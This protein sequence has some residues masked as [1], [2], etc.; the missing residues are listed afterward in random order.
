MQVSIDD[1]LEDLVES[2]DS[3]RDE[4]GDIAV[5]P[6]FQFAFMAGVKAVCKKFK[7]EIKSEKEPIDSNL[8]T[9]ER[10]RIEKYQHALELIRNAAKSWTNTNVVDYID[11]ILSEETTG[12]N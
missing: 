9:I 5:N 4:E 2:Y 7:I 8:Q 3:I 12:A 6:M 10:Y 1:F 11:Y